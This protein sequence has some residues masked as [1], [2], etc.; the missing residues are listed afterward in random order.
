MNHDTLVEH[1]I[2]EVAQHE[3]L[4]EQVVVVEKRV[5]HP[6]KL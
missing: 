5:T 3:L 2:H 4:G 1:T 6:T